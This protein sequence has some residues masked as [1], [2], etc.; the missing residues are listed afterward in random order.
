MS[1]IMFIA[2]L[3]YIVGYFWGIEVSKRLGWY[4]CKSSMSD[5]VILQSK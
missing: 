5:V 4:N 1:K 2:W 3:A